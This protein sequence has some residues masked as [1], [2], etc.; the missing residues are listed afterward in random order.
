[1]CEDE[2]ERAS[3]IWAE[4]VASCNSWVNGPGSFG[5]A[6]TLIVFI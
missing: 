6:L 1:M 5:P 4:E 2:G 3:G